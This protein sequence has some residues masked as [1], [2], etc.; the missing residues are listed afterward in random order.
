MSC[1]DLFGGTISLTHFEK[2]SIIIMKL[3]LPLE[4]YGNFLAKSN[5]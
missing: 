2:C 1:D 5:D 4:V 3:T